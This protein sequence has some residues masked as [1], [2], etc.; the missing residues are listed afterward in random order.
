M[1]G[2]YYSVEVD[3]NEARPGQFV[4]PGDHSNQLC[5]FI[6]D[7]YDDIAEIVLFE[8]TDLSNVDVVQILPMSEDWTAMMKSAI[9]RS[10]EDM[11]AEWQ[12]ILYGQH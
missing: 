10:S 3:G 5:G 1:I 8:P 12:R 6:Y 11:K 4:F 9:S 7:V 2:Q